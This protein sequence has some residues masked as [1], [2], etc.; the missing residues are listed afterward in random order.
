[1]P[2]H[3]RRPAAGIVLLVAPLLVG[4]GKTP[5]SSQPVRPV[6]AIRVGDIEAISGRKW[7]GRAKAADEV[8][9]SFRVSGPLVSLPIDV[10]Q[11]VKKGDVLAEIDPRD[12]EVALDSAT[13]DLQR[14]Q[15]TL[16]GMKVARPE[17]ITKAQ[18][19]L[20]RANAAYAK[21][22]ND[23][24][25]NKP[26]VASGA[27]TE[28]QLVRYEKEA[29]RTYQ[30]VRVATQTLQIA[31]AGARK[32]D[33]AAKE[34][35]IRTLAAAVDA[36]QD[37]VN[38]TRLVAPFDGRITARFVDN[39]QTVQAKEPIAR[40]IDAQ[41]IQMVVNIPEHLISLV[42]Y[43]TD[44]VCEFQALPGV[45]V[46]ATIKEVGTEA[47]ATT[48]T[49][50]ITLAMEQPPGAQ[51]LAGM[52]G[53]ASGR[54]KLPENVAEEGYDIPETAIWEN[55]Q[56]QPMVWLVD[57]A[58]NTVHAHRVTVSEPTARGIRVTGLKKEQ[59]VVTAGVHYLSEEQKVSLEP[60]MTSTGP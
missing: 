37:Q 42:P 27:I 54:V 28:Q 39:F 17:E 18:A 50:P 25:R 51:I 32:E 57:T 6:R 56:N 15:A 13:G 29:Q 36:A 14:A 9:L 12:F 4:C 40:L 44:V 11:E 35:E 55:D 2:N 53:T 46:P 48:R 30:E 3:P 21:A 16:E 58:D 34:A 49:Y 5:E 52:A 59:V 33:I 23:L 10:G 45:Q 41:K 26:L 22:Y 1:M 43:V 38:Y 19:E 20:D 47:S 60:E 24:M 31:K 8:N 7:P